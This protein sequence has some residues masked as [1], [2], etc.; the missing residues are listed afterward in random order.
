MSPT[1]SS[2]VI[3][4]EATPWIGVVTGCDIIGVYH[5]SDINAVLIGIGGIMRDLLKGAE[6]RQ[7]RL[8]GTARGIC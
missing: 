3:I 7:V 6:S 1:A 5:S 2:L 4:Q 8:P